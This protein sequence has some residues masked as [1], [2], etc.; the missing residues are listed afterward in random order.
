MKSILISMAVISML[1]TGITMARPNPT[2][3]VTQDKTKAFMRA[4]LVGSQ[5]V[6]DGLVTEDFAL[7]HR[8]AKSMK[9]LSE[10]LQWPR[11][12]DK[13]YDHFGDEFRRQCDKLMQL[14]DEK[15]LEGAHFTHLSMTTTCINCHNYVRGKFRVERDESNPQGPVRLIPSDWKGETFKPDRSTNVDRP[16]SVDRERR[17]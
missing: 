14:A 9:Q 7:I 1:F 13:V 16:T 2:D 12:E 10:A 6:L 11:A 15:N 5:M 17:N 4:K 3:L 8:G